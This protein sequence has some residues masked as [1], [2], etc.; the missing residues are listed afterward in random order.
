M[1][2]RQVLGTYYTHPDRRK[3]RDPDYSDKEVQGL[4][5][6]FGLETYDK[7]LSLLLG[8]GIRSAEWKAYNQPQMSHS[9]LPM[10]SKDSGELAASKD[11][12]H[13]RRNKG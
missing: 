12:K 9:R 10:K 13:A 8:I 5:N 4:M 3:Y 2:V 7:L 1:V 11:C 6:Y